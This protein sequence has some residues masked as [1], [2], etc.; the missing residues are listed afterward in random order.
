MQGCEGCKDLRGVSLGCEFCHPC[1]NHLE[2]LTL[3]HEGLK[4]I[5]QEL[6]KILIKMCSFAQNIGLLPLVVIIK[7]N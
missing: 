5:H 3:L 2:K 1:Y 4:A 7:K 6:T